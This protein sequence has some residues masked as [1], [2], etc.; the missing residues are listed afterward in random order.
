MNKAVKY[1]FILVIPAFLVSSLA[2][3]NTGRFAVNDD[4][5]RMGKIYFIPEVSLWFGTIT[6]IQAAPQLAYHITDRLSVGIG[7]HYIFYQTRSYTGIVGPKTHVWG[8]K[9]FSRVSVIRDASEFLPFYL[10]DELF[11]HVEY[12]RLSLDNT[13]FQHPSYPDDSRFWSDYIFVGPGISQRIGMYSSYSI[14]LL[15]NL[16]HDY[17]SLYSNPTYRIGLN[18]YF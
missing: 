3:Q 7:P 5:G 4:Q 11:F 9:G 6:N 16:N 14:L 1:I 2:G 8:I 10:F 13:Y 12:E 17:F 15:W 18:I